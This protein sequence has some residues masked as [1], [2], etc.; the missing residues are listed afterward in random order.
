MTLVSAWAAKGMNMVQPRGGLLKYDL[1]RDV[2]LRLEKVDP[3]LYQSL[4]KN[5]THFIP[6]PQI[7][8]KIYQK[9]HIIFQNC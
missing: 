3:F 8:S 2:P 6:E 4:P 7:L 5:E 9:F 1:G